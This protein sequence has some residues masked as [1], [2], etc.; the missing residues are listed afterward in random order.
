MESHLRSL[1]SAHMS[2]GP[3]PSAPERPVA[4]SGRLA[5]VS[6][7]AAAAVS[8]V[9][10]VAPGRNPTPWG[11]PVP[12]A[13]A[14]APKIFVVGCPRSGT[15]WVAD[16]L[17]RHP[18]T[19]TGPESHAY[20]IVH[21]EL[22]AHGPASLRAWSG[23]FYGMRRGAALGRPT[24]LQHYVDH[25]TLA[26]IGRSAIAGNVGVDA[27]AGAVIRGVYDAYYL[28]EGGT[29]AQALVEKTPR[30]VL[31]LDRILLDFPEAHVVEVVRDGRD[32]CVSM[33]MRAA[34]VPVVPADR[35]EQIQMWVDCVTKGI[36]VRRDPAAAS[37]I[38]VVR[39]EDL[40]A[41][42]EG[43]IHRLYTET[44]LG[45]AGD[46]A[47]DAAAATDISRYATAAGEFRFRGDRGAWVDHFD[48]DDVALFRALAGD[49]FVE[50]G[51]SFD[52]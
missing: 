51:Y 41:D 42:P 13:D 28:R 26:R 11:R 17:A 15:T 34:R 33:Q 4:L 37:R 9:A 35:R 46:L 12:R 18:A 36:D 5:A 29:G 2:D 47:G 44:G 25:A 45:G 3:G 16:T 14:G 49:V 21:G 24:G 27:T 31:W 23:I 19:I 52:D 7:K 50:A 38:T 20:P 32:V 6:L 30:H 1:S 8:A 22:L 48:A 39:Y 10:T 43:Q 40:K